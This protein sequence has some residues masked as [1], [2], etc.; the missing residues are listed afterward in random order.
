MPSAKCRN[1]IYWN[2]RKFRPIIKKVTVLRSQI[3]FTSTLFKG[4]WVSRWQSPWSQV[5]LT[6]SRR[7]KHLKLIAKSSTATEKYLPA[8]KAQFTKI[9]ENEI[10]EIKFR[11][12]IIVNC[13][14]FMYGTT[15]LCK[16]ICER[17][18]Y[19]CLQTNYEQLLD[20]NVIPSDPLY[21]KIIFFYS[22]FIAVHTALK[23]KFTHFVRAFSL[24]G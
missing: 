5:N 15:I 11:K 21:L 16:Q 3:K 4:W 13:A 24:Q 10:W 6:F 17:S 20:M 18:E 23:R 22:C 19:I 9:M 7:A 1:W 2:C 8:K 14:F 12:A